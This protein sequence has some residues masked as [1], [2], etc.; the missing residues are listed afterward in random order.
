MKRWPPE[1]SRSVCRHLQWQ[2]S[3]HQ[4]QRLD[5]PIAFSLLFFVAI[6]TCSRLHGFLMI[7]RCQ[8]AGQ[9]PSSRKT[10]DPAL[11]RNEWTGR[12]AVNKTSYV[13]FLLTTLSRHLFD[14]LKS[15]TL[16][17]DKNLVAFPALLCQIG[18]MPSGAH[19]STSCSVR[20]PR[21]QQLRVNNDE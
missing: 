12:D 14:L 17:T 1:E 20:S 4:T 16:Q 5:V 11:L 3:R 9:T 6:N 15:W 8:M 10:T 18:P 2:G 13:L 19:C 7:S 21:E